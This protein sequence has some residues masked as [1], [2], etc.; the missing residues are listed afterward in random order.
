MAKLF[1]GIALLVMLATAA[2][3][4]PRERQHRQVAIT[5]KETKGSVMR[6]SKP[7]QRRRKTEAE[8]GAGRTD[9]RQ[10]QGRRSDQ[11]A[12]RE[13]QREADDVTKKLA[14]QKMLVED[15]DQ[16][17]RGLTAKTNKPGRRRSSQ[18]DVED[19]RIAELKGNCEGAGGTGGSQAGQREH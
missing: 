18:A 8:E 17:S 14:E 12:G 15:K 10:H 9:G 11:G 6:R 16:G 4:F 1:I 19:P 7:R 2:L 13:D 5:L 3:G